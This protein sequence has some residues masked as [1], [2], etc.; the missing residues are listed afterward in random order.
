MKGSIVH[1]N[2]EELYIASF[3]VIVIDISSLILDVLFIPCG[4]GGM[5][6]LLFSGFIGFLGSVRFFFPATDH[7]SYSR[8]AQC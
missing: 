8:G 4:W 7:S 3:T 6:L 2:P 5:H 1:G